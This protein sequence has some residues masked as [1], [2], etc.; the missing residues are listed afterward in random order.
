MKPN[1]YHPT[2]RR[3]KRYVIIRVQRND[4]D[5]NLNQFEVKRYVTIRVQRNFM[6]I[7]GLFLYVKRYVIIRVQ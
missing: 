4:A 7:S 6:I 3:V 1:Q 5:L 2:K